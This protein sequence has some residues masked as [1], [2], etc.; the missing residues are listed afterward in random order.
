[1]QKFPK[2]FFR[3]ARKSWYV[4]IAG[5]QIAPR[6]RPRCGLSPLSRADGPAEDR[7]RRR[8]PPTLSWPCSTPTWTG[9]RT[10][11]PGAP[12]TGI[13][14]IWNPLPK[15]S[16]PALTIAG[17]KPFHV[18]Q[19]LDA[20][21]SWKTGKRGAVI[22]VQRGFNWAVRMG[23]IAAN[24]IRSLEKPKAGRRDHVIAAD[25][26]QTIFALVKDAQFRDLLTVCW[27]TGCRP[28]EALSVEAA[29]V[30]IEGGCWAF[31]VNESKGKQLQR[32]VYLTDTALA[33]TRRLMAVHPHGPLFGTPTDCRG[34]RP[35]STAASPGSGSP[36]AARRSNGWG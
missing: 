19:W 23:L 5:K 30:D 34:R 6:H 9:A 11:R 32:I 12:T 18:Q 31:P 4:Q 29:H 10:T 28:Q 7:T 13:V 15:R 8:S 27:E 17:L 24:P 16:R 1:M 20:N 35:P 26:F 2:P 14:I 21:P 33:I 36:S 22:A 25:Q 3:T